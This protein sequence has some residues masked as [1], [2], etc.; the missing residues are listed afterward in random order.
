MDSNDIRKRYD[1]SDPHQGRIASNILEL[2]PPLGCETTTG[3][4]ALIVVIRRIYTATMFRRHGIRDDEWVK[5]AEAANPILKHAWHMMGDS[6]KDMSDA[7]RARAELISTLGEEMNAGTSSF[8]ELCTSSLMNRTFWSQDVFSLCHPTLCI[9]AMQLKAETPDDK[10]TMSMVIMDRA[11]NPHITLQDA[12]NEKYGEKEQDG[13]RF[14]YI[15]HHPLVIRVLLRV[16]NEEGSDNWLRFNDVREFL[17]PEWEQRDVRGGVGLAEVSSFT[18][19]VIAVVKMRMDEATEHA[20]P[21][22]VDDG[23]MRDAVRTY[24]HE[25]INITAAY[26]DFTLMPERWSVGDETPYS[27]EY[28]LFYAPLTHDRVHNPSLLPEHN[29]TTAI[30]Y[31]DWMAINSALAPK[32]AEI[33]KKRAEAECQGQDP[34]GATPQND[35][36]VAQQAPARVPQTLWG[37][38]AIASADQGLLGQQGPSTDVEQ[39]GNDSGTHPPRRGQ[40]G[41]QARSSKRPSWTRGSPQLSQQEAFAQSQGVN[42]DGQ[43][44]RRKTQRSV[45]ESHAFMDSSSDPPHSSMTSM[46]SSQDRDKDKSQ[47]SSRC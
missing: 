43:S 32:V 7:S 6:D 47:H 24:T 10:A 8:K 39:F 27:Q 3:L 2:R 11:S 15:P 25:G 13:A 21:G 33:R 40:I 38:S 5:E 35:T 45:D 14:L 30:E 37:E 42:R 44:K 4:D 41:E 31:D 29:S 26:E 17:Q 18:Y 46:G 34:V 12:V 23:S 19:T 22:E 16:K 28:M 36:T 1:I 20:F 9:N